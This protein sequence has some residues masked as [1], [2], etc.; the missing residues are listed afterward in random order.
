[1]NVSHL[2]QAM[3]TIA[4]LELAAPW[5]NVGLLLGSGEQ[6]LRGPVLLTIDLTERVLG[7]ALAMKASAV[8]AYHPPIWEPLKRITGETPRGRIL[9]GAAAAGMAVY[10]PHTA[11]DAAP[12]GMTDWLAEGLS[13]G[14]EGTVAGDSRAIEPH[15]AREATQQVKIVT[16][17]PERS[18]DAVRSALATAGAGIIGDYQVCSF[19]T[20]GTGSFL[21]GDSTKPAVGRPGHLEQ[22]PE[23]RLEMVCSKAALP[24]ALETLSRFHPYEEPAV[25]VYELLGRPQRHH[26]PGRRIVLDQPATVAELA[27]RLKKH[28]NIQV[29][30]V[31]MAHD[32]DRAITHIG[33]CPGSG[34]SLAAAARADGCDV[35]ITGEMQHHDVIASLHS[36]LSLILA[37]HTNTERGYLPRL[38]RRLESMLSGVSFKVSAVDKSPRVPV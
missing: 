5:D 21:G 38:A 14:T 25:D 37:G 30:N 4:P 28:L 13:G 11:L 12:G 7:E 10:S 26:G 19:S 9:L 27:E 2:A 15:I 33:V 17:V 34:A 6:P 8:I 24:L 32:Q 1:M 22:V 20:L 35:Y 16:F 23:M 3:Q 36:G 29:V 31:A 18:L